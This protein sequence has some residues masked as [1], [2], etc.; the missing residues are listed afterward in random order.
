M[1]PMG[2]IEN[3]APQNMAY[4]TWM[5]NTCKQNG[6]TPLFV[7]VPSLVEWNDARSRA[8][9][10]WAHENDVTFVDFNRKADEIGIDWTTDTKDGGEHLN[11]SG[12]AKFTHYLGEYLAQ[13]N[14]L[15][16]HRSEDAYSQRWH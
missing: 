16:D 4:L 6:S 9:S 12:S 15:Q 8:I 11:V 13:N 3:P 14:Q 5:A 2:G 10:T 7:C 1:K